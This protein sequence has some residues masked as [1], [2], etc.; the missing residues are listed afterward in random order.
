MKRHLALLLLLMVAV[1]PVSADQD[2]VRCLR[3]IGVQPLLRIQFGLASDSD[4]IGYVRYQGSPGPIPLTLLKV[5]ELIRVDG[6]RPSEFE[7]QWA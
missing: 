1:P 3:S 2:N 7:T 4:S 6:G 5:T